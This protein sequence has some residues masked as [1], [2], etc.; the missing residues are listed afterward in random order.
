M[1]FKIQ[2]EYTNEFDQNYSSVIITDNYDKELVAEGH[3][4]SLEL[5]ADHCFNALRGL[6][7][8][9]ENIKQYINK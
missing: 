9:D 8:S 4:S 3:V 6:G 1:R 5:L 7:F 2:I